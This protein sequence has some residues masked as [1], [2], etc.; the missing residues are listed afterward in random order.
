MSFYCSGSSELQWPALCLASS[1][2]GL[3][4]L[5][6]F[7][8]LPPPESLMFSKLHRWPL[9]ILPHAAIPH[10]LTSSFHR[11]SRHLP[12]VLNRVRGEGGEAE[13]NHLESFGEKGVPTGDP[14]I[15]S[16]SHPRKK[17]DVIR[18]SYLAVLLGVE[19]PPSPENVTSR[20]SFQ[21]ITSSPFL[22]R[23]PNSGPEQVCVPGS[24]WFPF[25]WELPFSEWP[26]NQQGKET[27]SS[28]IPGE[29]SRFWS[30]DQGLRAQWRD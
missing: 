4:F 14:T 2:L 20:V 8:A 26:K 5:I 9:P 18:E 23:S 17:L 16:L 15:R 29:Q 12:V 30:D 21:F 1:H 27:P 13:G 3:P 11:I 24:P 22:L 10:G 19:R 28:L 6:L 7:I 25:L